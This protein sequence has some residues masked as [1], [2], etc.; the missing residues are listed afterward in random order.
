MT[1]KGFD[2]AAPLSADKAAAFYADGYEFVARYLV[3]TGWKRL[4]AEEAAA[5]SGT[6]LQIVSVFE[7][8]AD[9]AL[10][11]YE[12]GLADGKS[13]LA[14][15]KAIGQPAGSVIYFAVDF[16]VT[17]TQMETVISYIRAAGEATPG[18]NTGVYGSYSVVEAV[19]AAGACSSAWQTYAWS[20]RKRS[21]KA[22]IYQ[23]Q[24]D[25]TVNGIGVDLDE[26]YGAYGGWSMSKI[27]NQGVSNNMPM[28][29]EDWQWDMIYEVLGKAYNDGKLMWGW[30]QK[31][32]DKS[33]TATELAFLNTVLDGRIDRKIEV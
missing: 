14:A 16:N 8:S 27:E 5:I 12:A 30:M 13:A 18:Y 26:A 10:G 17:S 2:C 31:V 15:A 32:V 25:I 21:P 22:N 28:K 11:G 4:T 23:Y 3:P 1:V 7:T 29:L 33:M 6:G 19:L 20:G 24:N 9:R